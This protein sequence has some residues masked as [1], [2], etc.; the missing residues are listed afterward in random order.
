M[1]ILDARIEHARYVR[2]FGRVEA[3][4]AFLVKEDG[5]PVPHIVR[6]RTNE[7]ARGPAL[8][9]RLIAS[10]RALIRARPAPLQLAA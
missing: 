5:R 3:Q 6:V 2:D 1:R 4:V 7:A 10:A 8:R 9:A